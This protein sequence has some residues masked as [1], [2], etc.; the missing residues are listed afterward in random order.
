MPKRNDFKIRIKF[1]MK[2]DFILSTYLINCFLILSNCNVSFFIV[3]FLFQIFQVIFI[4][5]LIKKFYI[6][7]FLYHDLIL[8]I[9]NDE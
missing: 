1:L 9:L 4:V 5:Y 8:F 3:I 2:I 7:I 6:F